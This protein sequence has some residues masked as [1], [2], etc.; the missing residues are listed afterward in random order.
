MG[1]RH[2][3]HPKDSVRKACAHCGRSTHGHYLCDEC[4]Q[5]RHDRGWSD[6]D[7]QIVN[8]LLTD[9]FPTTEGSD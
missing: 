9:L 4:T 2:T 7:A 6:W 3:G 8:D 1:R 5:K